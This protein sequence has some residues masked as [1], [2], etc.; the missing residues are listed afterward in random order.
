MRYSQLPTPAADSGGNGRADGCPGRAKA[1]DGV[2]AGLAAAVEVQVPG[3]PRRRL[4]AGR[5]LVAV[6]RVQVQEGIRHR[7]RALPEAR[8]S[9]VHTLI[10]SQA[11]RR[12]EEG[13]VLL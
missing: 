10:P 12:L 5:G 7:A 2:V 1:T 8:N 4:E 13:C 11:A 6:R 3:R 9:E